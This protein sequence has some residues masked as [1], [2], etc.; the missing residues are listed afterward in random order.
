LFLVTTKRNKNEY[1]RVGFGQLS[2][3]GSP[4]MSWVSRISRQVITIV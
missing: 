2:D 4:Q 1:R 3:Y